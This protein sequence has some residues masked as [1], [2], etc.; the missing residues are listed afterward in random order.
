LARN[1]GAPATRASGGRRR[2][3]RGLL[4]PFRSPRLRFFF[5]HALIRWVLRPPRRRFRKEARL[6]KLLQLQTLDL[7]IEELTERET[8][9]PKQKSKY[10]IHRERLA[11]EMQASEQR[12]TRLVLEQRECEQEIKERQEHI[13]KYEGDLLKVKKNEEYQALLHEI[14]AEKK[15][16]GIKEERI[17]NI[18]MELDEA[19]AHY[20]EDKTRI[21]AELKQIEAECA[22]IDAEQETARKEREAL[23][24]QRLP[25]A[26]EVAAQML[27][28]YTRIRQ[29][30]K[31]GPAV[32]PINDEFCTG[33]H[34]KV[35]SQ[36]INEILAGEKLH[37]CSHCGRI[38]Y[39]PEKFGASAQTH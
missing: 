36:V 4:H 12:C 6:D 39:N 15:H 28:R 11:A 23:E 32:V 5:F 14:E 1:T 26:G 2:L 34:M 13:L 10:E 8:E 19:K 20:E 31:R 37:T 27:S 7:K 18:M 17:L 33:C 30:K 38:L 24:A 29:A 16:I 25:L 3:L 22:E 9:I 21:G 35:T